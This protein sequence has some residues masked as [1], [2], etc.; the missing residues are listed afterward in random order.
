MKTEGCRKVPGTLGAGSSQSPCTRFL[1]SCLPVIASALVLHPCGPASQHTDRCPPTA[2][3]RRSALY[4][5]SLLS[6]LIAVHPQPGSGEVPF[7]NL[8]VLPQVFPELK[9]F[10]TDPVRERTYLW[11]LHSTLCSHFPQALLHLHTTVF[12]TCG[13]SKTS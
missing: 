10:L 9:L 7:I 6:T 5:P 8:P 1:W 3:L 11:R 12:C 13:P 4:Q 2:W